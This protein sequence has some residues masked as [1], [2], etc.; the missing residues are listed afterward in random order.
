MLQDDSFL[1]ADPSSFLYSFVTGGHARS[2]NNRAQRYTIFLYRRNFSLINQSLLP[3]KHPN[4]PIFDICKWHQSALFRTFFRNAELFDDSFLKK[5]LNIWR[6]RKKGL[7][8]RR[9]F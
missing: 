9:Q 8:L 2:V 3:K 5:R 7:S 1:D 6:M 4:A